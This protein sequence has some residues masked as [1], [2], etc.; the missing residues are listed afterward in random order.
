MGKKITLRL[1]D[2]ETDF[3]HKLN[4]IGM[5]NSEAIKF[6]IDL[7]RTILDIEKYRDK[8]FKSALEQT[9]KDR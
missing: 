8:L 1:N 5:N 2:G 4:D 6:C 9:L 7:T 3:I